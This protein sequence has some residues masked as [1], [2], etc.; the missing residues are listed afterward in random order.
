MEQNKLPRNHKE[1][2]KEPQRTIGSLEPKEQ[3]TSP[4]NHKEAYKEPQITIGS[5]KISSEPLP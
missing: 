5:L 2:K 1:P 3:Y 4:R